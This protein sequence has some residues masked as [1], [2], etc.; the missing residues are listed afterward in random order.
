MSPGGHSIAVTMSAG[1]VTLWIDGDEIDRGRY[2]GLFMF[3]GVTT[4]AGGLWVGRHDGLE[5]D[6]SYRSP[7]IFT[8]TLHHLD[9]ESGSPSAG[10]SFAATMRLG[11]AS[12]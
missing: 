5:V 4:A 1:D 8:G 11:E 12:D 2:D 10:L 3:P 6:D 7:A 9:I